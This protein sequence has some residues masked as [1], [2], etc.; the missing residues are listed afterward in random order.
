MEPDR[1]GS[2][3]D[4]QSTEERV[5]EARLRVCLSVGVMAAWAIAFGRRELLGVGSSPPPE[6]SA[7]FLAIVAYLLG[8]GG[9]QE[10]RR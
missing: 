7:A 1:N 10:E 2:R 4:G 5:T 3:V 6:L 9:K 8:S